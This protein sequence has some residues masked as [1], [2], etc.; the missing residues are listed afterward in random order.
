MERDRKVPSGEHRD[1]NRGE[2]WR[3]TH[4]ADIVLLGE[5]PRFLAACVPDLRVSAGL[6]KRLNALL[7]P[8]L[9][10]PEPVDQCAKSECRGGKERKGQGME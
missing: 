6:D 4:R 2:S 10:S 5:H 3:V 7:P 9:V 1:K 8:L